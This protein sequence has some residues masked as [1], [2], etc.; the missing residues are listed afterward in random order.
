MKKNMGTADRTIRLLA[1]I[2]IGIL[3]MTGTLGGTI[4]TILGV[5]GIIFLVTSAF[6]ICLIYIP[7]NIS[8]RKKT[9]SQ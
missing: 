7:F 4:G 8:T 6:G 2:V 9:E 3:L 1:A 5:I